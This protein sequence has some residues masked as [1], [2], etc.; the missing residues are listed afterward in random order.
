MWTLIGV[1]EEVITDDLVPNVG[2]LVL[3]GG[4]RAGTAPRNSV[5]MILMCIWF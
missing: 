5:F 4:W 1:E 2:L 3:S